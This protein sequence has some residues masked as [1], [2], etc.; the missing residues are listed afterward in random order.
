MILDSR[1]RLR[2]KVNLLDL[3]ALLFVLS[4]S[5]TVG[6]AM[7]VSRHQSL[8]VVSIE[9]RWIVAGPDRY[10]M[11]KGTGFDQ[12]TTIEIGHYPLR[13]RVYFDESTIG[14]LINEEIEPGIQ[15]VV[16]RDGRGRY[17]ILKD[18]FEVIWE[19]KITEVKPRSIYNRG[20][21]TRIDIL[22]AFFTRSCSVRV[23]EQEFTLVEPVIPGRI[24]AELPKDSDRSLALGEHP[25]TVTNEGGQSVTLEGA[26]VTLPVPEV[27]SVVPNRVV[28]GDTVELEIRGRH[29][30]EGIRVWFEEQERPLGVATFV[31]PELLRLRFTADGTMRR[32]NDLI[33]ELPNGPKV[34]ALANAVAIDDALDVFMVLGVLLDDRSRHALRDLGQ[35]LDWKFKRPMNRARFSSRSRNFN[36]DAP[37]EIILP[38]RVWKKGGRFETMDIRYRPLRRGGSVDFSLEGRELSGTIVEGPF[39]VFP[40]DFFRHRKE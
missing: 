27:D 4:L 5:S 32:E 35:S 10:V 1:G 9:P 2:G 23:G 28:V 17:V 30:R 29:L 24:S 38:G 11:M 25:V 3:L 13:T 34:T 7:L 14:T 16:V 18:A 31:S 22:G 20:R 8:E 36:L 21:G 19:P 26:V 6:Y 40:E 12:S 37:F 33:L 15:R 39:T